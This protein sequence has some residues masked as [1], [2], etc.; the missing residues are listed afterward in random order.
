[1]GQAAPHNS[2]NISSSN[3]S[4]KFPKM[5]Q[6]P[7]E[8]AQYAMSLLSG[9][10]LEEA[11]NAFAEIC[12]VTPND[13]QVWVIA[14]AISGDL[15]LKDEAISYLR[16]AVGIDPDHEQAHLA[17]ATLLCD[18]GE[19]INALHACERALCIDPE[20]PEAWLVCSAVLGKLG[21]YEEA[22]TSARRA[23]ALAPE[24]ADAHVNLGNSL[25]A[26]GQHEAAVAEYRQALNLQPGLAKAH[27][28]LAESLA[29][30]GLFEDAQACCAEAGALAPRDPGLV[31]IQSRIHEHQ[32]RYQEAFDLLQPLLGSEAFE[33]SAAVTL[34]NAS[35][36]LDR[37]AEAAEILEEFLKRDDLLKNHR[38]QIHMALG[39][40]YDAMNSYDQA[41]RQF[42]QGNRLA[43]EYFNPRANAIVIKQYIDFFS[44]PRIDT[45]SR[46]DN[47]SELPVFIVG[48]PRS[49]TTLTEQILSSH[50]NIEGA[51]ELTAIN[52]I[53]NALAESDGVRGYPECMQ[54][55]SSETLTTHAD[56][57][58]RRLREVDASALR[59]V[60]KMPGN[61]MHLGL[62]QQ[63]FPRARIIHC[64]RNPLDTCLSCY[65]QTFHGH[66]YTNDL[67]HLG[68]YY[69]QYERL[70][71]HWR[72]VIKLPFLE[73]RYEDLVADTKGVSRK[74]VEFCGLPWDESCLQFHQNKR[75][76]RTASYQQ[77]RRPIYR[78]SMQR[79][80]HYEVHLQPL[81]EELG[82]DTRSYD[83]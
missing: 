50:R 62:I 83:V 67:R 44:I 75:T 82:I 11:R 65:F 72:E 39:H 46:A 48:M 54:A 25:D 1:L 24:I 41:F 63:L 6:I 77:V 42:Q 66:G 74:I 79:W 35:R 20:Y 7:S 15:G 3:L 38:R 18:K 12:R 81:V 57:Y 37:S 68:I 80:K 8:M 71:S 5:T 14:A 27:I 13:A 9:N 78:G 64:I 29:S 53:A 10:R 28:A 52:N 22:G 26:L 51:G 58:I 56:N 31:R 21:R 2:H 61:F 59:I 70:M 76:V 23:I 69:R 30:L 36:R 60:D 55:S 4:N 16:T 43:P 73:V 17:L 40:L 19:N 45:L 34:A 33:T 49:G 32:G 47:N